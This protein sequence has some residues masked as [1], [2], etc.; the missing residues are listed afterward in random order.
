MRWRCVREEKGTD[1]EDQNKIFIPALRLRGRKRN[2]KTI[3]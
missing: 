1:T 3:Y 2:E